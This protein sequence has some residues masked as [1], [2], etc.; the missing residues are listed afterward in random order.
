MPGSLLLIVNEN[1]SSSKGAAI[2]TVEKVRLKLGFFYFLWYNDLG[3]AR[4]WNAEKWNE[5]SLKLWT[6]KVWCP[7]IIC[8]VKLTQR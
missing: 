8:Y 6:L 5:E 4:C 7:G 3:D 2:Q 1:G